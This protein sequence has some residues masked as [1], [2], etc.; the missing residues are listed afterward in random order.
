MLP[1]LLQTQV[2]LFEVLCLSLSGQLVDSLADRTPGIE[3]ADD[4]RVRLQV[5]LRVAVM[6]GLVVVVASWYP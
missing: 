5:A 2:L 6:V 3:R 4:C 1:Q